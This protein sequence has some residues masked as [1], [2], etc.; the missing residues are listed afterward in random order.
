MQRLLG[1]KR[2]AWWTRVKGDEEP[3]PSFGLA[4]GS[5]IGPASFV[6]VRSPKIAKPKRSKSYIIGSLTTEI[7]KVGLVEGHTKEVF[8]EKQSFVNSV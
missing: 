5:T 8:L 2:N 4:V 7:G 1:Q 3:D 6:M